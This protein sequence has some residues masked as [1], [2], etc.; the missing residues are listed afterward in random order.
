[1][2][3]FGSLRSDPFSVQT[4]LF[5]FEGNPIVNPPI[6]F[7][8]YITSE[9]DIYIFTYTEHELQVKKRSSSFPLVKRDWIETRSACML[10]INPCS[11]ALP[12][13]EEAQLL[14]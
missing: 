12:V 10:I 2:Y 5:A 8:K 11:P 4:S 9:R 1:M 13:V 14:F 7:L 6:A 3:P